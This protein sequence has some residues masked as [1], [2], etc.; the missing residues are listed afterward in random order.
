MK[1]QRL[2]IFLAILGSFGPFLSTQAQ[3]LTP[4]Q[5]KQL[6]LSQLPEEIRFENL[7]FLLGGEKSPEAAINKIK[8]TLATQKINLNESRVKEIVKLIID[9]EM[10][11][12]SASDN[13][14]PVSEG[15]ILFELRNEIPEISK[16]LSREK[17]FID[18]AAAGKTSFGENPL[19]TKIKPMVE[20]GVNINAQDVEGGFTA[21]MKASNSGRPETVKF[22]LEH[23]AD[24]TIKN[25]NGDTALDLAS[26]SK[27]FRKKGYKSEIDEYNQVID[28]LQNYWPEKK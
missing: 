14:Y 4:E 8:T 3:E 21:L 13:R 15:W 26:P 23:G 16:K 25:E 9:T 12:R 2:F 19:E 17:M 28:L 24:R 6:Y 22:L 1:N 10:A 7:K 18:K 5:K 27:R 11:H 20:E